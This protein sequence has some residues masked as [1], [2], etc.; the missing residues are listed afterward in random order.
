MHED[1]FASI[2][3]LLWMLP[4]TCNFKLQS[5]KEYKGPLSIYLLVLICLA[6]KISAIDC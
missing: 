3:D 6:I 2:L 4:E 1:K 5:L